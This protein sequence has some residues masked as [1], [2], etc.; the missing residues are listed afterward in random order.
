MLGV[1]RT[2]AIEEEVPC[3]RRAY[4]LLPF[5]CLS[6]P[7]VLCCWAAWF[8]QI[9][10]PARSLMHVRLHAD[11]GCQQGEGGQH[12]QH[13]HRCLQGARLLRVLQV[14]RQGS[15]V[16][17]SPPLSRIASCSCSAMHAGHPLPLICT[18]CD[19]SLNCCSLVH[20]NTLSVSA[21]TF[22]EHG[23]LQRHC[24]YHHSQE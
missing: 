14:V 3:I 23:H 21:M 15:E 13:R 4:L 19:A 11:G 6:H 10:R 18:H 9:P 8:P 22:C 7:H 1:N 12:D 24:L 17:P 20:S 16:A 2:C 5:A